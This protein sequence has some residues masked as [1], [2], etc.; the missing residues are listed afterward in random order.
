MPRKHTDPLVFPEGE[1]TGIDVSKE[2]LVL[3]FYPSRTI[4]KRRND[5]SGR[6]EVAIILKKAGTPKTVLEATGGYERPVA[7]ALYQAGIPVFVVNPR[8]TSRFSE[9]IAQPAKTDALDAVTLARFA[10]H[11]VVP[12]YEPPSQE[13]MDLTSLVIRR[14]DLVRMRA[15]EKLRLRMALS[16]RAASIQ[17]MVA[18]IDEKLDDIEDRIRNLISGSEVWSRRMQ[19]LRSVPGVGEK[20]AYILIALLPEL[21]KYDNKAISRLAGLAPFTR[22]SGRYQGKSRIIGGRS[23]VRRALY[24]ATLSAIRHNPATKAFYQ[25]LKASGKHSKV[26]LIAC[27][28]K[29]LIVLNGLIKRNELWAPQGR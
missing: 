5:E 23:V 12:P 17:V 7:N 4:F 24:M 1:H 9:G 25:H 26:A 11:V 3:A 15:K 21:G 28:R 27:A 14:D 22:Q 19:I 16:H 6:A 10:S 8:Q 13:S 20:T 2:E 29:L 18:D